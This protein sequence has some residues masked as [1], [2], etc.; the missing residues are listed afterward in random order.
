MNPQNQELPAWESDLPERTA[1]FNAALHQ[2]LGKYELG[3][4]ARPKFSP[5]GRTEAESVIISMRKAPEVTAP[6]ETTTEP[7]TPTLSE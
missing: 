3:L 5:D 7:E 2:L 1:G 4:A 6:A